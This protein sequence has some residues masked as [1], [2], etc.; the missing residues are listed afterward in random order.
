MFVIMIDQL[1][2]V[3]QKKIAGHM[4]FANEMRACINAKFELWRQI[5]NLANLDY[6][7]TKQSN[8]NVI[9]VN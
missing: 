1:T 2:E 3:I 4:L 6:V 5:L 9:L 7:S 8:W